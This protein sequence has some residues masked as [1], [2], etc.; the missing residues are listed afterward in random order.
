MAEVPVEVWLLN[1]AVLL[2][3]AKL[4]EAFIIRIHLPKVLG[5]VLAGLLL[6][7]LNF[8]FD[9]VSRALSTLG[10]LLLL[11]HACLLYTSPSPR[12]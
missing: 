10:I 4:F 8:E 2:I 3:M 12:D 6:A 11:F 9:P 5:Y 7:S 1:V